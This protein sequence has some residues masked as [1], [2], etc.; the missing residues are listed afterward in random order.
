MTDKGVQTINRALDIIEILSMER[1]GLGVTEIGNRTGLHKS[2]AHRL[3]NTL[4]ERGYIEREPQNGSY[5][6]GLK[7]VEVSS[8]Y[9]NKI[10]LKTEAQPFLRKLVETVGQ[11]AHLAILNGT[12]AIY[13]EK[14]EALSSIRLYSQIGR[15]IP[16]YCSALGKAL[17]AG[18]N[19]SDL[20]KL[21]DQTDFYPYTQNTILNKADLLKS[22]DLVRKKGYAVD[23]EEHDEGVR[24]IAAPVYDYTGRII[25][26][27]STAGDKKIISKERDDEIGK[28]VKEAAE[29]ISRRM[30]YTN[31]VYP[32]F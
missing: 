20:N 15:R 32:A 22:V 24:C 29:G 3:L 23:D 9:L 18:L 31:P 30:G 7:F 26:S 1:Q 6:L 25:A 4:A 10:E 19:E 14:I 11:P 28:Y 12:D 21:A 5:R 8:I 16:A 13:I 17:M 2:T 27:V